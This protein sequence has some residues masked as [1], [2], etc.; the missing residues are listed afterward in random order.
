[1][2]AV[3]ALAVCVV[4][5]M[6]SAASAQ[7]SQPRPDSFSALAERLLPAV[8]NIS[9]TQAMP[10]R[11]GGPGGPGGPGPEMP[12]FPPGSPFEDLFREFFGDRAPPEMPGG[13]GTPGPRP[14]MQSLGSGFVIDP[15]GLIVTNN[16]VV[17]GAAEIEVTLQDET[18]LDAELVGK[19]PITDIA[20]LRVQP[21]KPLTAAPWGDS[22]GA[23]VGDWVLAIGNPFG[24]G[25]SVT[26][27][28]LSAHHRNIN[29]GPYDDF[30]QTDASINRGNSGGPMF[31]LAGEVIGINTAIF[32][33]TGGSVGIGFAIPS[34]LAR[35]VI[36][37]L[38]RD[39]K[40]E[41]GWIGVRIQP[42]TEE[43]AQS[44]GLDTA[45]GA[46][47]A[48][49]EPESPAAQAQLQPGDV[50]IGF[51][52][53][54]VQRIREL[55]RLV[56]ATPV[57]KPVEVTI[58]RDGKEEKTRITVGRL[59]PEKLL[60]AG[61][62]P[63]PEPSEPERPQTGALGLALAPLTPE[64]RQRFELDD[65]T[66]GVAIVDVAEDSP[67]GRKGLQSGD[68][69]VSVGT[70]PVSEPGQV[71]ERIETAKK[72]GRQSVLFRVQRDGSAQFIA[73]PMG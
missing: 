32:S 17:E 51:D 53:K 21:A 9:T 37:Q 45:R 27:G 54:P 4:L 73:V 22:A 56:A 7:S 3:R 69:I 25:G 19:D 72:A 70:D 40:V 55:P 64:L 26:A 52:G 20:L 8:V 1:M 60:A 41:R 50:I 5:A 42:V 66:K 33:P 11:P 62:G 59:D 39:G 10:E 15:S 18:T 65:A 46:L 48:D 43:I 71:A 6:P 24:L 38:A 47:V 57:E 28:I 67:A 49:V 23:K 14:R 36:E 68:V 31:N 35:P 44:L 58:W 61:R 30:L 34:S 12:Q 63:S 16:H 13:P 2:R 29:A